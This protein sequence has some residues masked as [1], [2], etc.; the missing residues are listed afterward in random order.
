M[1]TKRLSRMLNIKKKKP[2]DVEVATSNGR[3]KEQ[4]FL[5]DIQVKGVNAHEA[6]RLSKVVCMNQVTKL[7]NPVKNSAIEIAE[8]CHLKDLDLPVIRN[9]DIDLVIGNSYEELLDMVEVRR[10]DQC[11]LTANLSKFE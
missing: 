3:T 5:I 2:I 9:K 6:Y 1:A 8:Y 10:S 7:N 11:Q 4:G